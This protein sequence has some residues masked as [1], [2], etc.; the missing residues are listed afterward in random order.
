MQESGARRKHYGG[1][2]IDAM[3]LQVEG[4]AGWTAR[5]VIKHKDG[6]AL[7]PIGI[8]ASYE[9]PDGAL[10]MALSQAE[11]TIDV[12]VRM[13]EPAPQREGRPHLLA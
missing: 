2:I 9:N 5:F 13:P 8:H 6:A 1:Y 10:E 7:E 12:G 4:A 3:P 11:T